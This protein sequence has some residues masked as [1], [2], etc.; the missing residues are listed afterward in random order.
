MA[1]LEF[2]GIKFTGGKMFAVVTA[3]SALVGSLYGGF[4]VYKDYMD[5]KE[6]L[7][8]LEPA[9]I[10]AQIDQAMVKLDEVVGYARAIKDD[11]RS[12]V[13]AVE[14]AL[15]EVEQRIRGV[16]SEN[17]EN[18]RTFQEETRVMIKEAQRWFDE[19]TSDIDEKL[20]QLEERMD[21]KIRRALENPLVE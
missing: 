20:R 19:R 3:L 7:A 9:S 11:L 14:K 17:R 13:I 12:D 21:V 2:G 15:G 6:K 1:E 5:M 4:E 18:I 8:N 10:Q 16:E